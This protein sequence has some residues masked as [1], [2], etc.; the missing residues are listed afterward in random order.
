M[1][2]NTDLIPADSKELSPRQQKFLDVLFDE[3][4]GN[5]SEAMRLAG[6][7]SNTHSTE[8][9]N[10]LRDEIVERAKLYLALTS[11]EAYFGIRDVMVN[12]KQAGGQVKL[13]A[14]KEILD[15][16]G[17]VKKEEQHAPQ[18]VQNIFILPEKRPVEVLD[19]EYTVIE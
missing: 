14:A 11:A 10:R 7:S 12:P 8:V 5:F 4:K 9:V 19:G 15:R 13:N 18:A 2:E 6:Y 16:A 17:I 1:E 3:A